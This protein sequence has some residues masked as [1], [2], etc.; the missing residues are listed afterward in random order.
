MEKCGF[1]VVKRICCILAMAIGLVG[2]GNEE[3]VEEATPT[4]QISSMGVEETSFE[5]QEQKPY[6]VIDAMGYGNDESKILY[7]DGDVAGETF[8]IINTEN[9]STEFEG[10][11]YNM[12][13]GE[14]MICYGDFSAFDKSGQYVAYMNKYG[15]SYEFSIG[16]DTYT[17]LYNAIYEK[18]KNHESNSIED[19]CYMLT[20]LMLSSELYGENY[21]DWVYIVK[22]VDEIG[23]MIAKE[24]ENDSLA[25]SDDEICCLAG[26]LAKYGAVYYDI[27]EQKAM[28]K[29]EIAKQLYATRE[30]SQKLS[31]INY[32]ALI[33]L[34]SATGDGKYLSR[35]NEK[36]WES[37]D[38]TFFAD[39]EYIMTD[40][41]TDY[42]KCEQILDN[43]LDR[44]A[45]IFGRNDTIGESFV[46][47]ISDEELLSAIDELMVLGVE[48][49]VY[50]RNE[51]EI[52]RRNFI[53]YLC[54]CNIQAQNLLDQKGSGL[55]NE[56]VLA[57]LIFIMGIVKE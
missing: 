20:V 22:E 5:Y 49:Y 54:G 47:D 51:N 52:I 1:S 17:N 6:L 2:C 15:Y 36:Q 41:R 56:R 25:Y 55:D 26:M 44:D 21:T 24:L 8:S 43:Y 34:Y 12:K 35:V 27:N 9:G 39:M 30:L 37:G 13:V 28:E 16:S 38:F 29:T 40:Q 46:K 33:H 32:Y 11:M 23:N 42:S 4:P 31:D 57:K 45:E 48:D 18:M 3:I 14:K 53:H 50:S 7:V 10:I 19:R